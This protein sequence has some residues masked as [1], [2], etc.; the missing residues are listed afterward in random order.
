MRNRWPTG[1]VLLEKP[2]KRDCSEAKLTIEVTR[3]ARIYIVRFAISLELH[4]GFLAPVPPV[5][6]FFP[7]APR[8]L[9][10]GWAGAFFRA[11]DFFFPPDA[12]F[13]PFATWY[14]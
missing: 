13:A 11:P 3:F 4:D 8:L 1:Y 12:L 2:N 14:L 5:P 6:P 7:A 9:P 10:F